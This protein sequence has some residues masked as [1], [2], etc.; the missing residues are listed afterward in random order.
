MIINLRWCSQNVL[1][2]LPEIKSFVHH[3]NALRAN[4]LYSRYQIFMS[5][6]LHNLRRA[7]RE[8]FNSEAQPVKLLPELYNSSIFSL[9]TTDKLE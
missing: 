5:N 1:P 7:E 2:I 8:I 3:F 4:E 9:V 6:V